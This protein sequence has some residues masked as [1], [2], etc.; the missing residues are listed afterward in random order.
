MVVA[1]ALPR[2]VCRSSNPP[3]TAPERLETGT[4]NHEGIV[5]TAAA[6]DYLASLA[7]DDGEETSSSRR[8]RLRR[9]F[10]ALHERGRILTHRLWQSLSE[11]DGV[12]LFGPPPEA[13][14]T[15]TVSFVLAE[16]P[17]NDVS[18]RLAERGVFASHGDF[19]ATTVARRLG[20][21]AQGMVRIGCACYTTGEE[22]DRV[23]DGVRRIAGEGE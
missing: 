5:G 18:R 3:E 14:R 9:V 7:G 13:P 23:I 19:Y 21:S 16:R 12:R 20:V 6:V 2:S 15:P 4:Q 17:S 8:D 11:I 22:I 1:N 10:A